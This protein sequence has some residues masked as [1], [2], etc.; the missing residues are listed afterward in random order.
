MFPDVISDLS[1]KRE[2]EFAID[3]APGTSPMLMA[4]Y[5]VSA[6]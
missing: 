4:P 3:L 5:R 1:L 2:V 6:S